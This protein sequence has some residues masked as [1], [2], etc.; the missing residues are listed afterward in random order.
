MIETGTPSSQAAPY[1]IIVISSLSP[2]A[3]GIPS[4]WRANGI[5]VAMNYGGG[6]DE[7]V[8]SISGNFVDG[9]S[10]RI[11]GFRGH[12][13]ADDEPD[14]QE[15]AQRPLQHG[16]RRSRT[17]SSPNRY[18]AVSAVLTVWPRDARLD[19]RPPRSAPALGKQTVVR[20]R[21]SINSA[22]RGWCAR[23]YLHSCGA[24]N[25]PGAESTPS[26]NEV[27]AVL[28]LCLR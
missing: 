8:Q 5:T 15:V 10:Y 23:H 27:A 26:A 1:F 3:I 25:Q 2:R 16:Q 7:S 22:L 12:V 18:E 19:D 20:D 21:T 24:R 13:E 4:N 11:C 14:A 9:F 28:P 17:L 6:S